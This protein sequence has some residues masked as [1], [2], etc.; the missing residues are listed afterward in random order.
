MESEQNRSDRYGR[1]RVAAGDGNCLFRSIAVGLHGNDRQHFQVR[2]NAVAAAENNWN[3]LA[4]WTDFTNFD[5]YKNVMSKNGEWGSAMEVFALSS[6]YNR[7]FLIIKNGKILLDQGRMDDT[8]PILLRYSGHNHYDCYIEM[9]RSFDLS[10]SGV[11][12]MDT[13]VRDSVVENVRESEPSVVGEDDLDS[14]AESVAE[15]SRPVIRGRV[16]RAWHP[17]PPFDTHKREWR[18]RNERINNFY[19]NAVYHEDVDFDL[20]ETH[21]LGR[22]RWFCTFCGAAFWFSELY[23]KTGRSELCCSSGRNVLGEDAF[24]KKPVDLN[25]L[26]LYA[27]GKLNVDEYELMRHFGKFSRAYNSIFAMAHPRGNYAGLGMYGSGCPATSTAVI[28]RQVRFMADSHRTG[29]RRFNEAHL[30]FMDVSENT[31]NLRENRL[32]KI[33]KWA[34]QLYREEVENA[35]VNNREVREIVL[36][37]NP[38]IKDERNGP[39]KAGYHRRRISE[40]A[41]RISGLQFPRN[42]TIAGIYIG[43]RP[44]CY[45]DVEFVPR[46]LE[47]DAALPYREIFVITATLDLMLYSL[48]HLHAESSWNESADKVNT[49]R[50]YYRFRL[51]SDIPRTKGGRYWNVLDL[52]GKLRLQ[53]IIDAAVKIEYND[54][55]WAEKNQ[56]V[57]RS[58]TYD[59]LKRFLEMRTAEINEGNEGLARVRPGRIIILPATIPGTRRYYHNG[60]LDSLALCAKLRRV[61][62]YLLTFTSNKNWQEVIDEMNRRDKSVSDIGNFPEVLC[63]VFEQKLNALMGDLTER[64]ILGKIEGYVVRVEFQ[65]RGAPHAHILLYLSREDV[66]VSGEDVDRVIW[67]RWPEPSDGNGFESLRHLVNTFMIHNKCDIE[68]ENV[69]QEIDDNDEEEEQE[70]EIG[71]ENS[72]VRRP[73][74]WTVADRCRSRSKFFTDVLRVFAFLT[75]NK[76]VSS[77]TNLELCVGNPIQVCRYINAYVNKGLDVANIQ[78]VEMQVNTTTGTIDWNEAAAFLKMRYIGPHEAVYRIL[79]NGMFHI[80]HTIEKLPVHLEGETCEIYREGD[81]VAVV[82]RGERSKLAAWFELNAA[83][84]ATGRRRFY[85]DIVETHSWRQG[86]WVATSRPTSSIGRMSP[87]YPSPGNMER[88]YLRMILGNVTGLIS[89]VDAKTVNG[90][91]CPSYQAACVAL[92]LI[93]DDDEEADK[94]LDWIADRL[95]HPFYLREAFALILLYNPSKNPR[96]LFKRWCRRMSADVLRIH[97]DL[98]RDIDEEGA[99]DLNERMHVLR[100]CRYTVLWSF[101]DRFLVECSTSMEKINLPRDWISDWV[102]DEEAEQLLDEE[103]VTFEE[104]AFVPRP[105]QN[106]HLIDLNDQQLGFVYEV[107]QSVCNRNGIVFVLT[108]EGGTGKTATVNVIL[109]VTELRALPYVS[110]AFTGIAAT[111]IRNAATIHS[112]FGIPRERGVDDTPVSNL[113]GES[114]AAD[115]IRNARLVVLDEVFMLASW[116]LEMIDAVCREYGQ[117]RRPFGGKTVILSGDPKQLLPVV[118]GRRAGMASIISRPAWSTFQLCTLT[119]NMRVYPQ[120]VEWS[121]FIRRVGYGE[122]IVSDNGREPISDNCLFVPSKLI[123]KSREQ[124]VDFVYGDVFESMLALPGTNER[125][126]ELAERLALRSILCPVNSEV[127]ELNEIISKIFPDPSGSERVFLAT[128][129]YDRQ[130]NEDGADDHEIANPLA[131]GVTS[132]IIESLDLS[133]LPPHR[134]TLKIGSVVVLLVNLNV[135]RGFCNGQRMIVLEMGDDV[136]VG[137]IVSGQFQGRKCVIIRKQFVLKEKETP[138]LPGGGTF[139]RKQFPIKLAHAITINKAQGQTLSRVG[140][141]LNV[142][143]FAH[144]QFCFVQNPLKTITIPRLELCGAL[145]LAELVD[146]AK[147]ALNIN[148]DECYYWCDSTITLAWIKGSPHQWKIF[149]SNRVTQIQNLTETNSWQYV[150]TQENP[151]DLLSRGLSPIDFLKNKLWFNGTKLAI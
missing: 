109:E 113:V 21:Y 63:R 141:C 94:I 16:G 54:V 62:T 38:R 136:I 128:N 102:Y 9:R 84:E 27:G 72:R 3:D 139:Y 19:Q 6:F 119:E 143:C 103:E 69:E 142:P 96:T 37:V 118:K 17:L 80:S 77:A 10:R 100:T 2:S 68:P 101:V 78:C 131:T 36:C 87:V 108:G 117:S 66:P 149:V 151:A 93:P 144:G 46:P 112:S 97:I 130:S 28:N 121:N 88:Y 70:G 13:F 1:Y 47:E 86:R 89:F 55:S 5:D 58:D 20:I 134:L 104:F 34:G 115:D 150:N 105:N 116:M 48:V 41:A 42:E 123:V 133:G 15:A 23:L 138:L 60:Y 7:R 26:K 135:R 76:I 73:P 30:Y 122:R 140:L 29:N 126:L 114:E 39:R 57:L 85:V 91:L 18:I 11:E 8:N 50:Q 81:E 106:L 82:E 99:G 71:V 148:F 92:K 129:S 40:A 125:F 33:F 52:V 61:P 120:E 75:G 74:C 90:V 124:L 25:L 110:A 95:R 111:L 24:F 45:Y 49:L 22:E 4:V 127:E 35:A 137:R 59:S 83:E 147:R 44:P 146:K 107:L 145:L 31:A 65:K 32:C 53:Y 51:L 14:I 132:E 79:G 98:I 12:V 43:D 56:K 67:A 64:Q